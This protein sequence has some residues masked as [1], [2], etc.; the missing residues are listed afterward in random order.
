[1]KKTG[2]LLMMM[3]ALIPAAAAAQ[4]FYTLPE[5]RKQAAK[6]WHETYTDKYGRTRQVDY[7]PLQGRRCAVQGLHFLGRR[8]IKR[9][10]TP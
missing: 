2:A 5:I 10:A 4:E 7:E 9:R 6:G 1:M 8:E 3:L